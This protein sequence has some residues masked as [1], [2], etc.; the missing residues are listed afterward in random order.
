MGQPY[1][2]QNEDPRIR[3]G[4]IS[5]MINPPIN[6]CPVPQMAENPE[7]TQDSMRL[8]RTARISAET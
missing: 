7:K 3:P 2:I 4:S 6:V 5:L 8:S 1:F